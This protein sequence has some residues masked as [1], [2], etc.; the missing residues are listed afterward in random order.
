MVKV[1][2]RKKTKPPA[3]PVRIEQS[4][5]TVFRHPLR[6]VGK[7]TFH[8]GP[9]ETGIL[10]VHN[11]VV[12]MDRDTTAETLFARLSADQHWF[13][14]NHPG[15]YSVVSTNF[16]MSFSFIVMPDGTYHKGWTE[17]PALLRTLK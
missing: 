17:W 10:A 13:L 1:N 3:A 2:P 15:R 4:H 8:N 9:E 7:G 16:R 12:A 11:G 14:N 5:F 6:D